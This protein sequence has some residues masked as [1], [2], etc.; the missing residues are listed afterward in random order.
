MTIVFSSG[1]GT[2]SIAIL[3]LIKQ[4][5]LPQPDLIVFADTGREA[6]T[7]WDYINNYAPNMFPDIRVI[8]HDLSTVDL[9]NEKSDCLLPCYT[10]NGKL[11]TFC[12][13]EWKQ[14]PVRRYL[15]SVG[16]EK[17]D[18]W[19]G[20]SLDETHRMRVSDVQWIT[21]HYPLIFDIKLRRHES[22]KIVEDYGLPKPPRSRCWMCPNQSDEDWLSLTPGDM[23]K[24][25]E[26]ETQIREKDSG[27]WFH[28]SRVTLDKAEFKERA[29]LPLF[30]HCANECF[31]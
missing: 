30:E 24:A 17:C 2:Q 26:L 13:N 16:V 19:F 18:M 8:P 25:I 31:T 21:N 9:Y 6:Q 7:T 1:M 20:M 4:G 29:K 14:R 12:S 28:K 27:L 3:V 10:E 23:Q 15:R 11:P 22:I 5:R